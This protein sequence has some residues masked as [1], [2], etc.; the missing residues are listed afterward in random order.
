VYFHDMPQSI[1][2]KDI[3]AC[4]ISHF[5]P[6]CQFLADAH[7]GSLPNYSFIEPRYFANLFSNHI[8][9]DQHPPHNIL[10]GEQLI[11]Q[12]Y[13]ALRS[14]PCWSRTLFIITYDEHGGC[15]DHVAPPDAVSPDEAM[16][17]DYD[18][19]FNTYGVRVPAVI[20]SPYVPPGSIIRPPSTTP[21]DHTSIIKTV[22]ELFDLEG[23]LTARDEAAPS[24]IPALSL[25]APTNNGP[26][27]LTAATDSPPPSLFVL[28]GSSP[29]NGMQAALSAAATLLPS[30]APTSGSAVPDPVPLPDNT[31]VTVATAQNN[32]T[33]RTNQF[34]GLTI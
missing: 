26:T 22:R 16:Q 4:A 34:L 7:T 27:A 31:Y 21:F 15:Y 11:A 12:V 19:R 8:P 28:R 33:A 6:F 9:N 29:P 18:F 23:R 30:T 32:A 5:R 13:N 1:L 14:S 25:P 3:W 10:Y 20:V 2:L 24:L 17:N